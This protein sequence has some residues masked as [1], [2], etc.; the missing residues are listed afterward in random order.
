MQSAR[1][2]LFYDQ[3]APTE[4]LMQAGEMGKKNKCFFFFIFY[5]LHVGG[6]CMVYT[7]YLQQTVL[8]V[9][10]LMMSPIYC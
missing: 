4:Q 3:L 6:T 10:W 9:L 2:R 5:I 7:I 8:N 1:D